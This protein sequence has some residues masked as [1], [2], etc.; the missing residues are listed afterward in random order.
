MVDIIVD[1]D[2]LSAA[3]PSVSQDNLN[4]FFE[5]LNYVFIEA[6]ITTGMRQACFLAHTQHESGY[7]RFMKEN[8][9]YSAQRLLQ[10][11]PYYFKDWGTAQAYAGNPEKI[12]SRVYGSRLGNGPEAT[13]EGWIYRGRG[14]IQVTGKANYQDCGQFL[15]IDLINDPTYLETPEGAVRSAGWYWSYRNINQAADAGDMHLSTKLINGGYNGLEDR[16]NLYN[17]ALSVL[18]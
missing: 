16:I 8:L 5:P 6:D 12:A 3:C 13:K 4:L 10:V 1:F 14:L 9:N 2:R 11:F 18:G 15:N 17:Q 7:F